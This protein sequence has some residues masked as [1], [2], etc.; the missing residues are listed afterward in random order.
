MVSR[1]FEVPPTV[2][3]EFLCG[4]K[5]G[6]RSAL[7]S[8][9]LDSRKSAML[10]LRN[11]LHFE[12]QDG[13]ESTFICASTIVN[14]HLQKPPTAALNPRSILNTYKTRKVLRCLIDIFD[15]ISCVDHFH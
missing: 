13:H 3:G 7:L 6:F 15:S 14:F 4:S 11:L 2:H 5:G 12:G 8:S 9:D 10:L 1:D